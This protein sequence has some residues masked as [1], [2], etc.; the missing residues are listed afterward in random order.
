MLVTLYVSRSELGGEFGT[1]AVL[2]LWLRFGRFARFGAIRAGP[3]S[4]GLVLLFL[5]F[6]SLVF[7]L[8]SV[9]SKTMRSHKSAPSWTLHTALV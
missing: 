5:A 4:S 6:V 9:G 7:T 2:G 8:V 3:G 1:R